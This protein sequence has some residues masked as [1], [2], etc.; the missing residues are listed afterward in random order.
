MGLNWGQPGSGDEP[1]R[2]VALVVAYDGP[3]QPAT[4]LRILQYLPALKA[5]GI[6]CE[7]HFV[8]QGDGPRRLPDRGLLERADVVF[9]QR[10][11]SRGLLR[12][13][14]RSGKPV[15]F[16]VDDAIHLIRQSQYERAMEPVTLRDHAE[17][18]YRAVA[19]GGRF[20]SSRKRLLDE[21]ISIA[22]VTIVGNRWLYE[23]LGLE[24]SRAM[25]LPTAVWVD[26]APRVS[27][28][29]RTPITLGWTGVRS[30]LI[31]LEG[32]G[33]VFGRLAARFGAR[34]LLS[35][36]S[37]A[38]LQLPIAT[39][40]TPWSLDAEEDALRQFDIG[41][42]PLRDDPF[43]RGK[44]AFKAILCMSRGIP[45]V[46]SPV[47]ANRDVIEHGVN[48]FLASSDDE[49]IEHLT[50]LVE[51][52]SL[53]ARLGDQARATIESRFS[54]RRVTSGLHGALVHAA[55]G[56]PAPGSGGYEHDGRS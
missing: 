43:S 49:W 28:A 26:N 45:V 4:R 38:S 2:T 16:D 39:R 31:H 10:V 19:R 11:L 23:N 24:A 36:V 48:G 3:T 14:K 25:V 34:L 15:V 47:G 22:S 54:A 40:F 1:G 30:N 7:A 37:S 21:M 27:H 51:S 41:L 32:L 17:S 44:S 18:L 52:V 6:E 5:R 53:R 35:I 56:Q 29:P 12:L 42:M 46:A 55:G 8:A 20:Y 33:P 50:A 9:V 13:L